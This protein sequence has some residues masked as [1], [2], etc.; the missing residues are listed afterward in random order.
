MIVVSIIGA[1]IVLFL[2]LAAV[3]SIGSSL[4]RNFNYGLPEMSSIGMPMMDNYNVA[5]DEGKALRQESMMADIGGYGGGGMIYPVPTYSTG[6]TAEQ[7]EVIERSYT[8]QPHNSDKTCQMI[9]ELKARDD[10]IFENYNQYDHGCDARMKVTIDA[11]TEIQSYLDGLSPDDSS[12]NTYSIKQEFDY[13]E[14]RKELLE[15]RLEAITQTLEESQRAYDEIAQTAAQNADGE[16]LAI[17]ISSKLEMIERL[18]NQQLDLSTELQSIQQQ[19]ENQTDRFDY[20][21]YNVSVYEDP[22]F[23]GK[24]FADS[25]KRSVQSMLSSVN[26]GLQMLT[27]GLVQGAVWIIVYGVFLI[28]LVFIAKYVWRLIRKI[29]SD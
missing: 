3:S 11:S 1:L 16:A 22:Y 10:V 14:S 12:A 5:Y 27:T 29:W 25:W 8:Y 13:N 21:Y 19:V 20:H 15:A 6:D 7:Y 26:T 28:L 4:Y 2:C 17:V 18:T 24:G 9:Q 23:D